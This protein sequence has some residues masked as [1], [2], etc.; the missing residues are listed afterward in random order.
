TY[1]YND[2][3]W[4]TGVTSPDPDGP[5]SLSAPTV[6]YQYDLAGN[7]RIAFDPRSTM[8]NPIFTEYLY[9]GDGRLEQVIQAAVPLPTDPETLIHPTTT[10]DYDILGN[11]T[12]VIAPDPDGSGDLH[13][14]HTH[15]TYD[16][17]LRN[18]RIDVYPEGSPE[19]ARTTTYTFDLR[20][21]LTTVTTPDPD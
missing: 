3:G 7:L 11:V 10:Y 5:G 13:S 1:A 4:L 8:E 17:L 12:D 21:N 9:R 15:Y 6:G 2:A 19:S 18:T 16:G 14:L 20:G